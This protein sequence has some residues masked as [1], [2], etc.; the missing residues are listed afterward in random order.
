MLAVILDKTLYSSSVIVTSVNIFMNIFPQKASG[1]TQ[2]L[3]TD[4]LDLFQRNIARL[5]PSWPAR[6][7]EI[8]YTLNSTGHRSSEWTEVDWTRYQLV[9]GDSETL[10]IGL[11][12]EE[13][14]SS[15]LAESLSLQAV[16]CSEYQ[17]TH[18]DIVARIT[19]L[20]LRA[21]SLPRLIVVQWPSLRNQRYWYKGESV[22]VT[23]QEPQ[24]EAERYWWINYQRHQAEPSQLREELAQS[25]RTL[26]CLCQRANIAL[27]Q[28]TSDPKVHK[29]AEDLAHPLISHPGAGLGISEQL[30]FLARDVDLR[31]TTKL[32]RA[33]GWDTHA[34]TAHPG[35]Y[36]Q[37]RVLDAFWSAGVEIKY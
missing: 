34:V 36:H 1:T 6:S 22:L 31:K 16:N 3:Y 32:Q 23:G 2:W 7:A 25:R 5:P 12:L 18:Q 30:E 29:L 4:S 33:Q 28:F 10:G 9:I 8:T 21:P 26:E 19:T 37:Q 27:W 15:Q 11:A 24:T 20:L 14:W 35:L 13:L 17:L